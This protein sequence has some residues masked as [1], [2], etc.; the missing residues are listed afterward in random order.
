[1]FKIVIRGNYRASLVAAHANIH[2]NKL[3][4]AP[5]GLDPTA[6]DREIIP[7]EL[8]WDDI[9]EILSFQYKRGKNNGF[10]RSHSKRTF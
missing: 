8:L 3:R 5:I 4:N 9:L 2:F 6:F 1:M 10:K 7:Y